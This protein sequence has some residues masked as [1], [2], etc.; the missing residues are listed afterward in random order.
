M[1][2]E[3]FERDVKTQDAVFRNFEVIGEAANR[4]PEAIKSKYS[5]VEW[6]KI[7]GF[8][9]ILIHE[10][11]GVKLKTVW[12]AI[13]EKIPALEEQTK[14][15]LAKKRKKAW[16]GQRVVDSPW[17]VLGSGDTILNFFG[18]RPR[19]RVSFPAHPAASSNPRKNSSDPKAR[20]ESCDITE[21]THPLERGNELGKVSPELAV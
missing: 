16:S 5:G 21:C 12:T 7:I 18:L 3:E 9:N 17:L 10:Y 4:L 6:P 14:T 8:R 13:Q 2:F 11:L 20:S 15:V 19:S 1:S